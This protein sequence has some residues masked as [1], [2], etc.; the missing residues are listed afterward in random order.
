M[1]PTLQAILVDT[2]RIGVPVTFALGMSSPKFVCRVTRKCPPGV[3]GTA[4][5]MLLGA[6]IGTVLQHG[7]FYYIEKSQIQ[8]LPTKTAVLKVAP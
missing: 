1:N 5:F 4:G 3:L 7:L 6:F 8:G 2:I